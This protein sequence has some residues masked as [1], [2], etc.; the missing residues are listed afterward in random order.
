MATAGDVRLVGDTANYRGAVEYYDEFFRW[1]GV[2]ADSAHSSSW[3]SNTAAAEVVCAQLG[4]EGGR[5]FSL[6]YRTNRLHNQ[7]TLLIRTP[8]YNNQDT[9]SIRL[10]G[11]L[12]YT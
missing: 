7:D 6:R 2:C 12:H 3:T 11:S 8:G 1:T 10:E 9:N 5:P 4:Y